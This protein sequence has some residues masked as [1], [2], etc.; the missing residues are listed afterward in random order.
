MPTYMRLAA[1]VALVAVVG[2]GALAYFNGGP[3]IGAPPTPAP[4]PAARPRR[5]GAAPRKVHSRRVASV[6]WEACA[7]T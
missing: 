1:A 7:S 3:N 2:V 6:R 4:T 5:R